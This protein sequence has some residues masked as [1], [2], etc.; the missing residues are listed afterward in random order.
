MA[1]RIG[2][3]WNTNALRGEAP[4]SPYRSEGRSRRQSLARIPHCVEA[5]PGTAVPPRSQFD[6]SASH[7]Y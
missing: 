5:P 6:D 4:C 2:H 1:V 7:C 3:S